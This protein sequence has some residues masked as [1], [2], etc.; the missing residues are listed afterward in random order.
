V[1]GLT[2]S[3]GLQQSG[4]EQHAQGEA[5]VKQA[6]AEGYAE[7]T[8]D[9]LGGAKDSVLGAAKGDKSQQAQGELPTLT[10]LTTME[11]DIL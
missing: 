10:C 7:G 5:E 4:K 3:E 6:S 11:I 1:G 2:G 9:R 8:K